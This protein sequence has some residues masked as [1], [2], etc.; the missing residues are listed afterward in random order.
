[1]DSGVLRR[2]DLRK[3][4]YQMHSHLR[5][6]LTSIHGQRTNLGSTYLLF[7][8]VYRFPLRWWMMPL[9]VYSTTALSP[10]QPSYHQVFHRIMALRARITVAIHN[11]ND[12]VHNPIPRQSHGRIRHNQFPLKFVPA[13][14][15]LMT[16]CTI[17]S[18][19]SQSSQFSLIRSMA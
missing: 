18:V 11:S 19:S 13:R 2:L 14:L 8:L 9:S 6:S 5:S 15:D 7:C 10:S 3:E 4:K 16:R 12:L 17:S 1:M